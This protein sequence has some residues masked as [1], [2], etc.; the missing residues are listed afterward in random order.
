MIYFKGYDRIF[1]KYYG[2]ENFIYLAKKNIFE[3]IQEISNKTIR[4]QVE[5]NGL[6]RLH[7]FFSPDYLPFLVH[8]LKEKFNRLMYK[9]IYQTTSEDLKLKNKTFYIE[10]ENNYRI[11]YPFKIARR[12]KLTRQVYRSLNLKN[13][14]NADEQWT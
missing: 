5:K 7:H 10:K 11:H 9:Q 1:S 13:Y 3:S 6:D 4:N 14:K 8:L 12:S 2:K